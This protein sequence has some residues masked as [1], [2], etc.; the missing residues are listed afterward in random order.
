[1]A[2]PRSQRDQ[3]RAASEQQTEPKN[4]STYISQPM[5]AMFN[6][7]GMGMVNPMMGNMGM[8]P[9]MMGMG[10][11]GNMAGMGMGGMNGMMGMNGMGGMGGL[12]AFGTPP[13]PAD[14]RPPEERFQV[15]LEVRKRSVAAVV[16]VDH[17]G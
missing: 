9:M 13:A 5:N 15:Q 10:G 8:M 2:Q 11:M 17:A 3:Q 7:R 12:G 6:Q 16:V 4:G 1:M 14:S